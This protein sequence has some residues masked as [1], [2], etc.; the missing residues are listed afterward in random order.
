[1]LA[2]T[3]GNGRWKDIQ[4]KIMLAIHTAGHAQY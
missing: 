1:M 4:V 3:V 2:G